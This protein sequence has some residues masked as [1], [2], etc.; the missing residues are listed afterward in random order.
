MHFQTAR[1]YYLALSADK[2]YGVA[3]YFINILNEFE[4]IVTTGIWITVNSLISNSCLLM[5]S[6]AW[7]FN[8]V[9]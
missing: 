2:I 7:D 8:F 5:L 1:L 3:T 9:L 4:L 6:S